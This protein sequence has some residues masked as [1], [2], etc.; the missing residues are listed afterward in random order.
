MFVD[1]FE[2]TVERRGYVGERRRWMRRE[3]LF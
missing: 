2:H 3:S 1:G